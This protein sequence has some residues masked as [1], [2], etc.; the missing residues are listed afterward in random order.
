MIQGVPRSSPGGPFSSLPSPPHP[1]PARPGDS[2]WGVPRQSEAFLGIDLIPLGIYRPRVRWAAAPGADRDWCLDW[3]S[4]P[5]C[6]ARPRVGGFDS[7]TLPPHCRSPAWALPLA[8][9]DG[10]SSRDGHPGGRPSS[11]SEGALQHGWRQLMGEQR[12]PSQDVGNGVPSGGYLG[13]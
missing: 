3:S 5:A 10:V 11:L 6:P 8:G 4:K 2:G 1:P 7:H 13:R 12:L 9:A